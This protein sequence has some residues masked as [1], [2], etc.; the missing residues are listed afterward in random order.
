MHQKLTLEDKFY[1]HSPII[2]HFLCDCIE[3][4]FAQIETKL[5]HIETIQIFMTP[6]KRYESR[7]FQNIDMEI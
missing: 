6:I 4:F 2:K 1:L 7:S 5:R 3:I